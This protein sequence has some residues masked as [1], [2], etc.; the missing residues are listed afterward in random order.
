MKSC[1]S[2]VQTSNTFWF[3]GRQVKIIDTPGFDDTTRTDSDI[4]KEISKYLSESYVVFL[5]IFRGLKAASIS[6]I[7]AARD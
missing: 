2:T 4:L 1:T 5:R 6:G 3:E 7:E